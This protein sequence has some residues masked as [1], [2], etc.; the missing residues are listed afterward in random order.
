VLKDVAGKVMGYVLLLRDIT[1]NK[2]AERALLNEKKTIEGILE[3]S[4]IA[5]FV[6]DR[7]HRVTH[8]NQACERLTGK[9]KGDMIGTQSQWQ[10][11]YEKPRP[12][13]A[14]G[15]I[16]KDLSLLER[17]YGEKGLKESTVIP[18]AYEAE[19]FFPRLGPGGRTL[20]FLAAP[21]V[22]PEGE[23]Q[24]VITT[25][26]DVTEQR[27]AETVIRRNIREIERAY[28]ELKSAQEQLVQSARLA[29][30]GKLAATIAHEIN[31]PLAGVLNYIKLLIKFFQKESFPSDRLED[32]RGFLAIMERE[33]ARCG[34]IV[35]NLLSFSRPSVVRKEPAQVNEIIEQALG[36]L[37]HKIE[38]S[39]A[40][41]V[42]SLTADLPPVTCDPKQIQ[43]ALMNIIIN[44]VEAMP[45]GG[46][47]TISSRRRDSEEMVEVEIRDTGIG[48]P[49]AHLENLFEPFFSTKA[50]GKGVGLGLSVSYGIISKHGGTISVESAPGQGTAFVVLL[51]YGENPAGIAATPYP[52]GQSEQP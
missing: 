9:N 38:I 29:S 22:D 52:D 25:L 5:T 17:Y 11:F 51:P 34:D 44:G 23:V 4:P 40:R 50:E 24:G 7:Q 46:T 8:W 14:D 45:Q 16:E 32:I 39:G 20:F 43:Q 19:D 21:I 31:N 13:L 3:G 48:I 47:L 33:T 12:V 41:L 18:G 27:R 15:I 6:V 26:Q 1:E 42:K 10:A 30:L 36:I 35:K 49:K 37:T 28:D 2:R